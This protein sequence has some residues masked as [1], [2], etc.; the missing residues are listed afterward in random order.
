M[1]ND[2]SITSVTEMPLLSNIN[3]TLEPEFNFS[4]SV[5]IF[6]EYEKSRKMQK[7]KVILEANRI[8]YDIVTWNNLFDDDFLTLPRL[9]SLHSIN[10]ATFIFDNGQVYAN[11][12]SW[13]KEILHNYCKRFDLGIIVLSEATSSSKETDWLKLSDLPVWVKYGTTDLYNTELNPKSTLLQIA[14]PGGVL[15]ENLP[16]SKHSVFFSNE[17]SYEAVA[18]SFREE[19]TIYET[20][21]FQ[22][23]DAA[24]SSYTMPYEAR[25]SK[26]IS[27]MYDTGKHDGIKRVFFGARVDN[28]WMYR[29]LFLDALS[30]SSNGVLNNTDLHRWILID[31]D[32][33][34]VAHKGTRMK[35]EDVEVLLVCLVYTLKVIKFETFLKLFSHFTLQRSD[36][37]LTSMNPVQYQETTRD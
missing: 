13:N 37:Q 22:K 19:D 5:L 10:Y 16:E 20:L 33:I 26:Y 14:K 11:M 34:F 18:Y 1:K 8:F 15:E 35:K 27:V 28:Y 23:S 17:S 31:I 4:R 32:D 29:L 9:V 6:T 36:I 21:N 12:D 25:K 24:T 30:V 3:T 7:L 2:D